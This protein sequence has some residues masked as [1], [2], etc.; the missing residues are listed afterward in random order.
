MVAYATLI[1]FYYILLVEARIIPL[2]PP[3]VNLLLLINYKR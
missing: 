2:I 3:H 1:I